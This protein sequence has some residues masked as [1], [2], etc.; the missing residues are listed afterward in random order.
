MDMKTSHPVS[1]PNLY[2]IAGGDIRTGRGTDGAPLQKQDRIAHELL[3]GEAGSLGN[4]R[5]GY[6]E[7]ANAETG[8]AWTTPRHR[9][10]FE[11]V[12]HPL[13]GDYSIAGDQVLPAG[14]VAYFPESAYYGPQKLS[15]N[16]KSV[17]LQYGGPSGLGYMSAGQRK[18]GLA[19]L[20]KK[21]ELKDGIY[22]WTTP[23]GRTHNQDAHEALWEEVRGE[24]TSYPQARYDSLIMMNPASFP[25]IRDDSLTGVARK[26][27]GVFT[28]RDVRIGFVQLEAGA[29]LPFGTQPSSEILFLKQGEIRHGD[30]KYPRLSAFGSDAADSPE[31][32]VATEDSELFY[33]KMCTFA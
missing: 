29:E 24:K 28:E 13:E 1:A 2:E 6:S 14:W 25:W 27:L 10:I 21:G 8:N 32:L 30:T 23:D 7:S 12:R 4:Y 3:T 20:L 11:Q 19:E 18:A 5:L 16:L 31:T 17:V 33:V 26:T 9:H 15:P 22:S